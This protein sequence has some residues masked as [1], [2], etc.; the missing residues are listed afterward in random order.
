MLT[1]IYVT[2]YVTQSPLRIDLVFESMTDHLTTMHCA[3]KT[4][5]FLTLLLVVFSSKNISIDNSK[6]RVK[7]KQGIILLLDESIYK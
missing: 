6:G 1:E 4:F 7:R 2:I 5:K 3:K